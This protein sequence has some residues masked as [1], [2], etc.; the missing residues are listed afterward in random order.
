MT[1]MSFILLFYLLLLF[2]LF[3]HKQ[4]NG[5][6]VLYETV[7]NNTI[8][9]IWLEVGFTYLDDTN[10]F[11]IT[12]KNDEFQHDVVAF[13]S[14]PDIG[15][16]L[17]NE[18]IPLVPKM[19]QLPSKNVDNTWSF[20]T[21]LIQ[22]KGSRCSTEWYTPVPIDP[23]QVSWMVV[24]QNMIEMSIFDDDGEFKYYQSLLIGA[25]EI[26]RNNSDSDLSDGSTDGNGN[27]NRV[28]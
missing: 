2:I 6:R 4:V 10:W 12:T 28:W 17:Y 26:T 7:S 1:N 19:Q 3:L 22:A 15:G 11:T 18:S 20:T 27:F 24:E 8:E 21:K 25:N 5:Q 9:H 23:V 13:I 16:S 14:L